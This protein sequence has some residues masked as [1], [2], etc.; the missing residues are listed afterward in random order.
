MMRDEEESGLSRRLIV[1]HAVDNL[2]EV[3]ALGE[4]KRFLPQT[5]RF[6]AD[7]EDV[8][9]RLL[10]VDELPQLLES[11]LDAFFI[12]RQKV[13]AGFRLQL[14]R[15]R[16]EPGWRVDSLVDADRNDACVF[17]QPVAECFRHALKVAHHRQTAS[18]TSR[19][20]RIN[21]DSLSLEQ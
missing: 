2:H 10:C 16:F 9:V 14:L 17:A 12:A 19:E 7:D 1:D 4:S 15:I 20:E 8:E 11:K 3:F 13:P 6:V 21:D 5:C 18:L